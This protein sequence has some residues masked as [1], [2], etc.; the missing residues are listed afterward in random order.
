MLILWVKNLIVMKLVI[1]NMVCARCLMA[2]QQLLHD[3]GIETTSV[4]LGEAD[5]QGDLSPEL[6]AKVKQSLS[7]IGFEL[8]ESPEK[9]LVERTK[10][11]IIEHVRK[12]GG[13]QFNL[14]ACIENHVG[15]DARKLSRL[16]SAYEG[17]TIENYMMCQRIEYV[18]ELLGYGQLTLSEISYKLGFSSVAHLSRTFK[19][20]TGMT[21]T[22][23]REVSGERLPLDKV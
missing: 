16:F 7:A 20:V 17:R 12:D 19:Q 8:I 2:V 4:S 9:E 18:K 15:V 21:P 1:K 13:C 11:A 6:Y 14:S 23:Y 10:H 22:Q 3:L 5:I